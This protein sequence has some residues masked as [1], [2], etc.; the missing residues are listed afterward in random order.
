LKLDA[1]I[2]AP[3]KFEKSDTSPILMLSTCATSMSLTCGHR[4]PGT[5]TRLAGEHFWPW[6]SNAPR[7]IVVASATGSALACATMKS[8]P[9]VYPTSRG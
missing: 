1:S 5:Y 3:M 6:Y 4:L 8:L 2:T 9:P 7:V